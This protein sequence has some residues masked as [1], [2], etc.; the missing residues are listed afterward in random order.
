MIHAAV[1]AN[2]ANAALNTFIACSV[3]AGLPSTHRTE[4]A[5]GSWPHGS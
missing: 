3:P 2:E 5:N 1:E 4:Q